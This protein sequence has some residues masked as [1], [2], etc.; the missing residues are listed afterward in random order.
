[1]HCGR[2]CGHG[3]G[4]GGVTGADEAGLEIAGGLIAD[5]VTGEFG[6]LVGGAEV[7]V[8]PPVH[9]VQMVEMLVMTV[10]ETVWLV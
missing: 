1:M 5:V 7:K 8:V 4:A 2:T 10:V 6:V 9:F 3:A